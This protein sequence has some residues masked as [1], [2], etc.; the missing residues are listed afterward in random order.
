MVRHTNYSL[1]EHGPVAELQR[2]EKKQMVIADI[3]H[4]A[5]LLSHNPSTVADEDERSSKCAPTAS[6]VGVS[7]ALE[8]AIPS[9]DEANPE[10]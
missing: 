6:K 10:P 9:G 3:I 8:A 7:A 2:A 4:R 1:F 5:T